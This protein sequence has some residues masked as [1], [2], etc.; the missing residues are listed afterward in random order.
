MMK[1]GKKVF[2]KDKELYQE[3]MTWINNFMKSKGYNEDIFRDIDDYDLSS[4]DYDYYYGL[5]TPEQLKEEEK[6]RKR[7]EERKKG[8]KGIGK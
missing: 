7:Q 5:K 3:R 2:D 1:K 8:I 6:A 4:D